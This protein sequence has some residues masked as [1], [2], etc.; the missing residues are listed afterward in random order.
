MAS[1]KSGWIWI[2]S[3]TPDFFLNDPD[4]AARNVGAAHANDVAAALASIEQK[5]VGKPWARAQRPLGL[6]LGQFGIGPGMVAAGLVRGHLLR[7]RVRANLTAVERD[8][9]H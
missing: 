8:L 2:E 5:G 7:Q 3:T 1:A 4:R 9:E 6:E